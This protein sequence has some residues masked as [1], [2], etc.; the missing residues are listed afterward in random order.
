[1]IKISPFWFAAILAFPIAASAALHETYDGI[2]SVIYTDFRIGDEIKGASTIELPNGGVGW[3]DFRPVYEEKSY[4]PGYIA[5][6]RAEGDTQGL[7]LRN[8]ITL[9]C[10]HFDACVPNGL[11]A[12]KK[13]SNY[14]GTYEGYEIYVTDYSEFKRVCQ[15][16]DEYL[17]NFQMFRG[18][19]QLHDIADETADLSWEGCWN[20]PK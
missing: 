2:A 10:A 14:N 7:L 20:H 16:L 1:M 4:H 9:D 8:F 11:N 3:F 19:L 6:I 18:N 13:Y 12:R 15:L 17:D 5:F